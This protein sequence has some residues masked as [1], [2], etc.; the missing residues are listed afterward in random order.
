MPWLIQ[1]LSAVFMLVFIGFVLAHF[2]VDPPGSYQAWRSWVGYPGVSVATF[3][4]FAALLTHAWVGL[5]DVT[6]DYVKPLAARVAVL[7][8]IALGLMTLHAMAA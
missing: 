6:L 4:F 2:L 5:R 8:L 3:V 7:A 1:R